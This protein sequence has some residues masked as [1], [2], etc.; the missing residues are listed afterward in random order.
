MRTCGQGYTRLEKVSSL[1]NF[2]ML[3]T[4]NKYDKIVKKLLCATKS[5]AQVMQDACDDLYAAKDT[6]TT[7][8]VNTAASCDGSWH[9]SLNGVFTVIS[10]KNGK[11]LDVEA[12]SRVCKRCTLIEKLRIKDPE[13]YDFMG[14]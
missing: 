6:K 1:M 9:S 12:M 11:V 7:S 14:W 3:K 8:I 13:A 10:M 5:V 2:L 4:A